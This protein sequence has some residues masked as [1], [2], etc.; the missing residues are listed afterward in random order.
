MEVKGCVVSG[1]A[2][3]QKITNDLLPHS[4]GFSQFPFANFEII[5]CWSS[6]MKSNCVLDPPVVTSRAFD[7]AA[8]GYARG[9]QTWTGTRFFTIR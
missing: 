4:R 3:Q 2:K 7:A 6:D 8:N 1:V 9:V 5:P